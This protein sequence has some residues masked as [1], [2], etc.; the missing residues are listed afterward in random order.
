[1][2]VCTK[3]SCRRVAQNG[4]IKTMKK[5]NHRI[6]DNASSL[7]LSLNFQHIC[8]FHFCKKP[9]LFTSNVQNVPINF[10]LTND[11]LSIIYY[12]CVSKDRPVA[13]LFSCVRKIE[14][15][16]F[17]TSST[18]LSSCKHIFLAKF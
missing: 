9:Q 7:S 17:P 13:L 6:T 18:L 16:I 8:C 12:K 15:P 10:N 14:S 4:P 1:M 3:N 11:G 5:K 2:E